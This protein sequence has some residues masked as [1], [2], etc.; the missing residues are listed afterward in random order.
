MRM[1]VYYSKVLPYY[2]IKVSVMKFI[3]Y[4]LFNIKLIYE[5]EC[6][7]VSKNRQCI[8]PEENEF[9]RIHSY[10]NTYICKY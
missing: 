2:T 8:I 4:L 10:K 6:I 5:Y 1:Y 3:I 7:Y 9:L